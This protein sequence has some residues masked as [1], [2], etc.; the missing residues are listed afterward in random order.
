M[1]TSFV[2]CGCRR[3]GELMS[4]IFTAVPPPY[5]S[6]LADFSPY[7]RRCAEIDTAA[8]LIKSKDAFAAIAAEPEVSSRDLG[9]YWERP[10]KKFLA[11]GGCPCY[12]GELNYGSGANVLCDAVQE[13]L[14][15]YVGLK[16]CEGGRKVYCPIWKEKSSKLI[17]PKLGTG[18]D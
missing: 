7:S 1:Q 16:F 15:G 4:E 9:V 3:W 14:H 2:G 13:Q 18:E 12:Q 11:E 6:K 17:V 5:E 8:L 10:S